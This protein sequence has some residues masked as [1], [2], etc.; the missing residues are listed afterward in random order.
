MEML[1][2]V[3]VYLLSLNTIYLLKQM[4]KEFSSRKRLKLSCS[5]L[6]EVFF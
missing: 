6:G 3:Q 1:M 4:R 2:R 5:Y